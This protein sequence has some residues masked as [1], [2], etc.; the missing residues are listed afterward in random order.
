M[1]ELQQRAPSA[2]APEA[3]ICPVSS[4]GSSGLVWLAYGQPRDTNPTRGCSRQRWRRRCYRPGWKR[5]TRSRQRCWPCRGLCQAGRF[6]GFPIVHQKS[7]GE[8]FARRMCCL[9]RGRPGRQAS[10]FSVPIG[11]PRGQFSQGFGV[12][13]RHLQKGLRRA[14]GGAATL[15]PVLQSAYA[16]AQQLSEIRL[17]QAYAA[18][19]FADMRRMPSCAARCRGGILH[20]SSKI[21]WL[22]CM[23]SQ[24][25]GGP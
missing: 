7:R 9:C 6:R 18:A 20:S 2:A 16:H 12:Q 11:A 22:L 21:G 5:Q 13:H 8:R 17:R 1:R 4:A 3:R 19:R 23:A 10:R 24:R 15:F 14:R 25:R